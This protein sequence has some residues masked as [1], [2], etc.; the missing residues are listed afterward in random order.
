MV[1]AGPDGEPEMAV[2]ADPSTGMIRTIARN[3]DGGPLPGEET[4]D[5]TLTR[6]IPVRGLR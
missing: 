4:A 2:L 5:V 1:L 6:G 3:R